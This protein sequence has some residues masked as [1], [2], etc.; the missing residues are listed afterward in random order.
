MCTY[1]YT[2]V[3]I[4]HIVDII[5]KEV[6]ESGEISEVFEYEGCILYIFDF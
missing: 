2:Y 3:Y 4:S 5:T 6:F 1:I